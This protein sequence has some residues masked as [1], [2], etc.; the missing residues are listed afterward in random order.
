MTVTREDSANAP[1]AA[2]PSPEP[3]TH[4][5]AARWKV[6]ALFRI[7]LGFVFLWPFL[8]KTFGLGYST[9]SERAWIDGG[10]PTQGFL[11]NAAG[12]PFKGVFESIASPVTDILFMVGLLGI[13]L[14]VVLG[15]GLRVAAVSGAL[16]M[17]LMYLAQWPLEAGSSN[18]IVD[19]H[20]IYGL[21]V[22]VVALF[23]AGNTWG[24]GKNWAELGLVKSNPWLK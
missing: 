5:G 19:S 4:D 1:T 17:T 15:I 10:K 20:V 14:A 24:L 22:V 12:G 21:G 18:P 7:A 6:L 2:A 11:T 13:G 8:D 23:A 3:T 9:P 16:L